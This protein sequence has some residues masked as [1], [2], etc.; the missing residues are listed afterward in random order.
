MGE[1]NIFFSEKVLSSTKKRFDDLAKIF[2]LNQ[3]Q[4]IRAVRRCDVSVEMTRDPRVVFIEIVVS[5]NRSSISRATKSR[6]NLLS[7]LGTRGPKFSE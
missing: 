4:E 7:D 1:S 3:F 5:I 6:S 2:S